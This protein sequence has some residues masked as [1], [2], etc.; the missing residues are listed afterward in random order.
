MVSSCLLGAC[1]TTSTLTNTSSNNKY[2]TISSSHPIG[3]RNSQLSL[4][5]KRKPLLSINVSSMNLLHHQLPTCKLDSILQTSLVP[6][7]ASLAAA[8]LFFSPAANA[9]LLSGST[10]IESVPGP[11]LPKIEFLNKF[12]EENQK[13]Y[14]ENDARFKDSP[15]LKELLEKS[16]LNKDKNKQA[17][18]D[19][20]CLRGAEW[21]V[22]DCSTDGMRPDERDE[23]IAMLK[24]K[25][26]IE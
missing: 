3:I 25:T 10:G 5:S 7:T 19:K 1:F 12:N 17:I 6:F 9:G 13:R 16:K 23:F 21:G 26:G 11:E 18:Q 4:Y 24:K 8:L 15:V 2:T 14:A 20:Y 22:G